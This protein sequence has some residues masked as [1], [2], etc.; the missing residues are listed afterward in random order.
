MC[1]TIYHRGIFSPL[2]LVLLIWMQMKF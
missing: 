2:L 1:F